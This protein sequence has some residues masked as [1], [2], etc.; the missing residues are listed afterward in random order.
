MINKIPLTLSLRVGDHMGDTERRDIDLYV[1]DKGAIV[2][3]DGHYWHHTDFK[4]LGNRRE[5]ARGRLQMRL[6]AINE[7]FLAFNINKYSKY[8]SASSVAYITNKMLSKV[9]ILKRGLYR[10][11]T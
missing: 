6:D 9:R 2:D 10:V 5:I 1:T 7:K 8:T 3:G 4:R 11:T